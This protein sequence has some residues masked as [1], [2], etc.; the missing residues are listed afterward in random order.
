MTFLCRVLNECSIEMILQ[1]CQTDLI[2]IKLI[3]SVLCNLPYK[4]L[5]VNELYLQNVHALY[6]K[7]RDDLL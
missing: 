4:N 1:F 7:T 6:S 3:Y 2:K 5:I